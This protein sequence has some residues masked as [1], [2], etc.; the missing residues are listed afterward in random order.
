MECAFALGLA[1]SMRCFADGEL[2]ES[3]ENTALASVG[4]NL[5][6]KERSGVFMELSRESLCG[7][8]VAEMKIQSDRTKK[9]PRQRRRCCFFRGV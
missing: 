4:K 8:V 5:A 9:R 6:E 3:A 2:H 7:L 1:S